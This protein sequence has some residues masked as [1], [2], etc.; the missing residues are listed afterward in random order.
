[1]VCKK[2]GGDMEFE[3]RVDD[4]EKADISEEKVWVCTECGYEFKMNY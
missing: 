2:C 4:T 1:M 3:I